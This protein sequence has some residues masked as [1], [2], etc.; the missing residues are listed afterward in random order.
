MNLWYGIKVNDSRLIKLYDDINN[1]YEQKYIEDTNILD[2]EILNTYFNLDI[3]QTDYVSVKEKILVRK[4]KFINKNTIPL[5]INLI[6]H[7]SLLSSSNNAVGGMFKENSLIQ[8]MHDYTFSVFSKKEILSYQINNTQ[9][10]ILDGLIN[11]KDYIGTTKDSSISYEVGKINP[12][13]E[14]EIEVIISIYDNAKLSMEQILDDIKRI[15]K[16]DLKQDFEKTKNYWRKY[17][18][19]HNI[20]NLPEAE[21]EIRSKIEKIY[22]RT[23]LLY[24]LL[25]NYETGGI[26]AAAEVDENYSKSGRYSYCW[27]RDALHITKA[28]ATLGMDKEVEKFYKT[29]CNKTQSASGMWE[30]RFYTDGTLA[31]SWGYQIDETAS[32][33]CGVYD[34]Y[35]KKQNINF[36]KDNL[37]MCEKA[38]SFLQKYVK[39]I[40]ENKE[41]MPLSYDLWENFESIHTY[42]L[43][44]IFSAF[45]DMKSIFEKVKPSYENNRLKIEKINK[46][47]IILD[48][49]LIKI[50]NY[51]LKN[52]YDKDKNCF[53]RNIDD[54]KV[55]ISL[56]GL[57]TPFN[58]F[59]PKEKIIQNTIEK[60]NMTLR[61][62]TGGYLRYEDDNYI[63][64]NNPWIISNLWMAEYYLDAGNKKLA[65]ECFKFAVISANKHGLLPEQINNQTR[66]LWVI[67]LGWSHAMFIDILSRLFL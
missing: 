14:G 28:M 49:F 30:Q 8:Y 48:E 63:G 1:M 19:K 62:Y 39:D 47:L 21:S 6:I 33:I 20:I 17:V 25:V 57:V 41:E 16:I 5:D 35:C 15:K 58:M 56:L 53:K 50:K 65:K 40:I 42:S 38:S 18:A 66:E 43:A 10:N 67:G 9:N 34:Y 52:L 11:G 61:T 2:T 45:N 13:E 31:P 12:G 32:V 24:P 7:S 37:K 4:Y 60:I 27:P 29:F 51:I 54:N 3:H 26:S 23:I 36:L 64:G 59:S 44:S 22:K 55:D 46:E